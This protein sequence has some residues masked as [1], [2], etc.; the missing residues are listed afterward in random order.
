MIE[1]NLSF[2]SYFCS[3]RKM[4]FLKKFKALHYQLHVS[5][6]VSKEKYYTKLSSSLADPLTS[7][8][9]YWSILKLFWNNKK[10]PCITTL[11]HEKKFIADFNLNK[12][13]G[14]DMISIWMI[15]VCGNSICKP[16][17]I[18]FNDC[19]NKGKFR[20]EWKKANVL[21]THMK[22][23]K[24]SLKNY[25][26]LSLLPICTKISEQLI[27]SKMYTI[28]TEKNLIYPNQSW[29]RPVDYCVNQLLAISH[30]IYKS[31]D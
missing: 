11:S 7:P 22:G 25:R 8:K 16:I 6:E 19:L 24:Q 21:A 31:F 14:H 20:H 27:Y 12:T 1:K 5:I 26:P 18:I 9:T 10:I 17:S 2:K 4:F 15:K 30:K 3:N 13:H 29:F 28:F 23:N